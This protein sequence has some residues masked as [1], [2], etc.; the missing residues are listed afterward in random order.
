[1]APSLVNQ[2]A[3][4]F[5]L[6][7]IQREFP[8][9]MSSNPVF[10]GCPPGVVAAPARWRP[11]LSP[12]VPVRQARFSPSV[13]KNKGIHFGGVGDMISSGINAIDG[14]RVLELLILDFLGMLAPRTAIATGCRGVDDGRETFIR[15]TTG[16]ICVG[17]L[18]GFI[19][20][21]LVNAAG[22]HA[23]WHNPHGTPAKAWIHGKNLSAFSRMYEEALNGP[24]GNAEEARARFIRRVLQGLESSDKSLSIEG[25][26]ATLKCLA[27]G[28]GGEADAGRL[29]NQMLND[30]YGDKLTPAIRQK[31]HTA[32]RTGL[33]TGDMTQLRSFMLHEAG[34]GKLSEIGERELREWFHPQK[35][36]ELNGVKGTTPLDAR[37]HQQLDELEKNSAVEGS[38]KRLYKAAPSDGPGGVG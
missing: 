27:E 21:V 26:L 17:L 25:R 31:A 3:G 1:M 8:A 23:G 19:H 33:H 15:E 32:L 35:P 7:I 24:V 37:V 2:E 6:S 5:T 10:P 34:W 12:V 18:A 16:I 38:G 9:S 28:A 14:H 4:H 11:S 13:E 29:L 30:R 36:D 20:L 22:N